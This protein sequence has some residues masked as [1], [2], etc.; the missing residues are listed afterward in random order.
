MLT[1]KGFIDRHSLQL[2]KCRGPVLG[3]PGP[4]SMCWQYDERPDIR[5]T[6]NRNRGHNIRA[7]EQSDGQWL[8]FWFLLS[9][10]VQA[11]ARV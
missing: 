7:V 3:H 10:F 11:Y 2:R 6:A 4:N 1:N 5:R 8:R 9:D